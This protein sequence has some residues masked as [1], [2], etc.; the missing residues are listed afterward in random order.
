VLSSTKAESWRN[1]IGAQLAAIKRMPRLVRSFFRTVA[2]VT[3]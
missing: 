3:D 1:K 2:Y